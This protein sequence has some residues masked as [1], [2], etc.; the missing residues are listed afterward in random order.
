[1]LLANFAKELDLLRDRRAVVLLSGGLDSTVALFLAIQ[2]NI[3]VIGLEFSYQGRAEN[4]KEATKAICHFANIP[5]YCIDYSSIFQSEEQ[6]TSS[7]AL[8][9][10]TMV[11]YSLAASFASTH[12]I[13]HIIGGQIR[14]D[15]ERWKATQAHPNFYKRLNH[16][17]SLEYGEEAPSILT[18]LINLYKHNVVKIGIAIK[19]PLELTWSCEKSGVEPC[20]QCFQCK[21]RNEA[22]LNSATDTVEEI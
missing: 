13:S 10:S 9:E 22:F 20:L 11:Y 4:E 1:M 6:L 2:R 15:W 18:P 14:E 16:L 21:E 12:K 17:L 5:L 19:A 8:R 7:I 3:K